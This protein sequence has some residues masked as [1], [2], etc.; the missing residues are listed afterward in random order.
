VRRGDL[1]IVAAPGEFGKPR[2]AVIL[3]ADLSMADDTITYVPITSIL[4]RVPL[5]RIPIEPSA[6]NGL[7]K[8]S[9]LMVDR[10]QTSTLSRVGDFIGHIDGK[11]MGRVESALMVHLGLV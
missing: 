10:I 1:I 3:Q 6:E 7:R 4:Q 8:P 11:T 2:P 5:I 9:E